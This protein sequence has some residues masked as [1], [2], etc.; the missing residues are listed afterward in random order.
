MARSL[1]RGEIWYY[2]FLKPDKKRPVLVL[3]RDSIIP[4]LNEVTVAPITS[5]IRGIPT[6]VKVGSAE[7]LVK[8]SA[9]N[10]DHLQTVAKSKLKTFVGVTSEDKMTEI[11]KALLFA[12]GFHENS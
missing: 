12:M 8:E 10:L 5:V 6:E 11:M 2:H 3:T 9:V 7:G 4:Y 1:T